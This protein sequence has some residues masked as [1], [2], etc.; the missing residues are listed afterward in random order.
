[1]EGDGNGAEPP[2]VNGE[3]EE[4]R[5]NAEKVKEEANKCFKGKLKPSFQ[6]YSIRAIF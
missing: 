1:M 4:S 2:E 5:E 3:F 6:I